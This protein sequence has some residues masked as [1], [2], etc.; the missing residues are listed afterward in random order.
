MNRF[1]ERQPDYIKN[2]YQLICQAL[3]KE[4]KECFSVWFKVKQG[5]NELPQQFYYRLLKA[6]FGSHNELGMEEDINFKPLFVQNFHPATS[7]H[8]GVL[9]NPCMV[10]IWQLRELATL[11]FQNQKQKRQKE[12]S[13][14]LALNAGCPLPTLLT[15][16]H[17]SIAFG[18]FAPISSPMSA[19]I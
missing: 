10:M 19:S 17:G 12:P 13:V 18:T 6:Y 3:E 4:F 15:T 16:S 8:L 11:A 7:H 14:A 2:D 9:A 1:I 5:R